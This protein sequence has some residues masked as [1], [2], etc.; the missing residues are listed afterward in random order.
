[1]TKLLFLIDGFVLVLLYRVSIYLCHL[2]AD[3][4]QNIWGDAVGAR[5]MPLFVLAFIVVF[6][7]LAREYFLLREGPS[8]R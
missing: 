7:V 4:M 1:M 3:E 6:G 8:E 2:F 5:F